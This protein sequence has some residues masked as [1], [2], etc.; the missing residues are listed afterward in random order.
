MRSCNSNGLYLGA[1]QSVSPVAT[2]INYKLS[3]VFPSFVVDS[4]GRAQLTTA[5]L[6]ANGKYQVCPCEYIARLDRVL[7]EKFF[8][9][10]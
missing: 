4:Q 5:V 6:D 1:N 2:G 9:S 8:L 10:V 7:P 3:T